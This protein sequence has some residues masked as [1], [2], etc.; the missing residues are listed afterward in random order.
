MWL[1]LFPALLVDSF[2]S[3]GE[4]GYNFPEGLFKIW[5]WGVFMMGPVELGVWLIVCFHVVVWGPSALSHPPSCLICLFI[6]MDISMGRDFVDID[7]STCL[8]PSLQMLRH[9]LKCREVDVEVLR[10]WLKELPMGLQH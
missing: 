4:E 9:G 3:Y 10:V 2:R 7:V 1:Y 5:E 8:D 6:P